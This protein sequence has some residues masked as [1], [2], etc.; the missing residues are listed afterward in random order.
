MNGMKNIVHLCDC[1]DF[2]KGLPDNAYDLAIVDPPY[3]SNILVKNKRQRHK[4]T[5]TY[6]NDSAPGPVYFRELRRISSAQIIWG[7]QYM[8]EH[9]NPDGSFIIW[10][11]KADPDLHNMSACDVA[12]YSKRARIKRFSGH[13]CGAVKFESEPTIHIHQKPVG[14][15]RWLLQNYAKPG[16]TIFDSHVGSGS[17]R[18]ACHDLGFDF[19]G[20]EIDAD[21]HAAQDARFAA[22][23]SQGRLLEP[24]EIRQPEQMDLAEQEDSDGSVS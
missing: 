19:E 10:D 15:Y 7:C 17:I 9:L 4:D 6:K 16:Q 12:W 5:G 13:W 20:C 1:M 11:K 2:M 18:I 24:E 14:L 23:K 8:L 22:H 21:Y 3:G